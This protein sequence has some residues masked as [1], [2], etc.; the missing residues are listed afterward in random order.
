VES[1]VFEDDWRRAEAYVGLDDL[2]SADL[3]WEFLRRNPA[4]RS[5]YAAFRRGDFADGDPDAEGC[6]FARWGL[7]FPADPAQPARLEPVFWRPDIYAQTIVLAAAPSG[8]PHAI[9]YRP[10]TWPGVFVE[11]IGCDGHHALL[12]APD[13]PHRL[14]LPQ[15]IPDGTPVACMVPLGA[16]AAQGAAAILRFWR[17]LTGSGL[18]AAPAPDSRLRRLR[19]SLKAL[20]GHDQG[21]SYRSLAEALFGAQR[22]ADETWRTSSLRDATIRLVRTGQLLVGGQYRRLLGC[23]IEE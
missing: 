6:R 10:T 22:V 2:S 8:A 13:G 20:D 1:A 3:A 18:A 16:D 9:A 4:Y 23:R 14:W 5:D 19:L 21:A 11:Q 7:S 17:A 12:R 15:P